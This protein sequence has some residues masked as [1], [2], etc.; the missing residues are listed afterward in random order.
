ME[1]YGSIYCELRKVV[2]NKMSVIPACSRSFVVGTFLAGIKEEALP[3]LEA[4]IE[5]RD[6]FGKN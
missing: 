2:M 3:V 4:E 5:I 6:S 1:G